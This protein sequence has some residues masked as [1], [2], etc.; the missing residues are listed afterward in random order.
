MTSP[1]SEHLRNRPK[2]VCPTTRSDERGTLRY[3]LNVAVR[4]KSL[5]SELSKKSI[6][7]EGYW[8]GKTLA[9]LLKHRTWARPCRPTSQSSR[10]TLSW[11]DRGKAKQPCAKILRNVLKI[12]GYFSSI[13]DLQQSHIDP[14]FWCPHPFGHSCGFSYVLLV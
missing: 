14:K 10:L 9:V 11:L 1:S 13:L 7:P 8:A 3:A 2:Q 12:G 6:I 4:Y 5:H